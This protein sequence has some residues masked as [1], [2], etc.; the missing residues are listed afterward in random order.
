MVDDDRHILVSSRERLFL[1]MTDVSQII[2]LQLRFG[3]LFLAKFYEL[4]SLH[5][6]VF[7]TVKAQKNGTA[8]FVNVTRD[9]KSVSSLRSFK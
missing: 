8:N 1:V 4:I 5:N 6:Q 7:K 3:K 2:M 9:F